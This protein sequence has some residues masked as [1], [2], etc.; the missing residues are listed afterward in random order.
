[1]NKNLKTITNL[2]IQLNSVEI[3]K[4]YFFIYN[5]IYNLFFDEN[6][7][8]KKER[9]V[10]IKTCAKTKINLSLLFSLHVKC[11]K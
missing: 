8:R 3:N 1:M 11:H 7:I 2:F 9:H 10:E 4:I 6:R 5:F